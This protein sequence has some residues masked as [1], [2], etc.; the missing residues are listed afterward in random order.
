MGVSPKYKGRKIATLDLL[1]D[2]IQKQKGL[3]KLIIRLAAVQAVILICLAGAIAGLTTLER[4]AWEE[5][6]AL[7]RQV[8]VIRQSPAIAAIAHIREINRQL[9]AEEAFIAEIAPADF[10]PE[11]LKSIIQADTGNMTVLD[12]RGTGILITGITG[13]LTAIETHRQ[14]LRDAEMFRDVRLGRII[15]QDNG[16]YF[17]ELHVEI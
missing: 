4:Q 1:P 14:N 5:S 12:Y 9:A 16:Q 3:R 7:T 13:D 10:N 8:Q 6:H 15:R 2:N 11:W 17:Y